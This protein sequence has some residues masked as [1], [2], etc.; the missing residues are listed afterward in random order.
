MVKEGKLE[1]YKGRLDDRIGVVRLRVVKQSYDVEW[2]CEV[3]D[4]LA[5]GERFVIGTD[6]A[7]QLGIWLEG[8]GT[9]LSPSSSRFLTPT[10]NTDG[11]L[12]LLRGVA[13]LGAEE[14]EDLGGLHD[15]PDELAEFA[16]QDWRQEDRVPEADLR[17]LEFLVS[18]AVS[19]NKMLLQTD[20]CIHP[21]AVVR[22]ETGDQPA[23]YVNQYSVADRLKPLV[24]EKIRC[25]TPNKAST[26]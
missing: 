26:V 8:V 11:G 17:R 2:D 19:E 4:S 18:E 15:V 16:T 14:D 7:P 3:V 9:N 1:D 5:G 20:F 13:R 21:Q 6:L 25:A 22:V 23:V 10:G 24:D 12:R